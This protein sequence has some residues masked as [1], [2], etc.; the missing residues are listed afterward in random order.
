LEML[1]GF[2]VAAL[3]QP[4][5]NRGSDIMQTI[6]TVRYDDKAPEIARR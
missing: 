4:S 2:E 5:T 6:Y 3:K 1:F